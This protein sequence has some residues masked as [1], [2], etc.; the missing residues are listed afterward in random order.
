MLAPAHKKHVCNIGKLALL[1]LYSDKLRALEVLLA[2]LFVIGKYEKYSI[3]MLL[4]YLADSVLVIFLG[5]Q[6][7]DLD[8]LGINVVGLRTWILTDSQ[9]SI[10]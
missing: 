9:H 2:P 5:A 8:V 7:V 4:P 6:V 3:G 1:K 10:C